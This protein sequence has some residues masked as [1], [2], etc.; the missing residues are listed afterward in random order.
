MGKRNW[1]HQPRP[2]LRGELLVNRAVSAVKGL[3]HYELIDSKRNDG[4]KLTHSQL[5]SYISS[6]QTLVKM[7]ME[8]MQK[9]YQKRLQEEV[10][11]IEAETKATAAVSP[12]AVPKQHHKH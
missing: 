5:E 9:H 12:Y 6:M 1:T 4:I 11:R 3:F 2:S 8:N 10:D 7:H